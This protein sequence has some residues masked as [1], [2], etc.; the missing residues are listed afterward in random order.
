MSQFCFAKAGIAITATIADTNNIAARTEMMRLTLNPRL[1]KQLSAGR[2]ERELMR[3]GSARIWDIC[4][5][6]GRLTDA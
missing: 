2:N 1:L 3:W 4:P 6:Y 5:I